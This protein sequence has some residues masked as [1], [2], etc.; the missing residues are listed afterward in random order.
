MGDDEIL[1]KVMRFAQA[2][3]G[4]EVRQFLVYTDRGSEIEVLVHDRQ[5]DAPTGR[6]SVEL[7]RPDPSVDQRSHSGNPGRTIDEALSNA[8]WEQ[9]R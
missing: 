2:E 9:F 3:E 5:F 8:H 6:Y 4:Y 7:R 1:S